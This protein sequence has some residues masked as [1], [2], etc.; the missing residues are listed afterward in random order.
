MCAPQGQ[1]AG[2]DD[3]EVK[4]PSAG[5]VCAGALPQGHYLIVPTVWCFDALIIG[6]SE[7]LKGE[8]VR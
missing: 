6:L 8:M 1:T 3:K 7:A 2:S 5:P 4:H